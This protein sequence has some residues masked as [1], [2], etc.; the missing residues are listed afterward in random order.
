MARY[1]RSIAYK[2]YPM[3]PLPRKDE[4]MRI[5]QIIKN[6]FRNFCST[7][8]MQVNHEIC[9]SVNPM[10]KCPNCGKNRLISQFTTKDDNQI[11]VK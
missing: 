10:G 4:G 8:R 3:P 2:T 6:Y 7:C 1:S 9:S 5:Y 11:Q